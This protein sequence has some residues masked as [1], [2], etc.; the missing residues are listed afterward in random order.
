MLIKI[1]S[2][3]IWQGKYLNKISDFLK[4]CD[5]DIVCL[6]EVVQNEYGKENIATFLAHELSYEYV[7]AT[8]MQIKK[9]N[10]ELDMGNAILSKYEIID[11]KIHVLGKSQTRVAIQAGV[12][13]N[14]KIIHI[15]CTHLIHAHQQPSIIQDEQADDLIK[16]LPLDNIILCGDFNAV[17]QSKTIRKLSNVLTN[18][19]SQFIPTW[20]V[21]KEGCEVCNPKGVIYKLDNIFV[22]EDVK[23]ASFNVEQSNA[24]DHLPISVKVEV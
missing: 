16:I 13:I 24:S 4:Q 15:L 2:W 21:Y 12:K 22:S 9:R 6:Q 10:N 3:N 17:P 1:L 19:D 23:F 18:T 20:S 11:K 5:A 14:E 7:Y 8:A